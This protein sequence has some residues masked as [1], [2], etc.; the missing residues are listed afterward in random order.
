MDCTT[1]DKKLPKSAINIGGSTLEELCAELNR[2]GVQA[3][4]NPNKGLFGGMPRI[5]GHSQGVYLK[6]YFQEPL[7][8]WLTDYVFHVELSFD[9][10]YE[11]AAQ[12]IYG[13]FVQYSPQTANKPA[14][15]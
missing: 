4:F 6:A 13:I 9:K 1:L 3:V 14:P 11:A 5:E 12:T 2:Q 10:K 15:K 7:R 8:W